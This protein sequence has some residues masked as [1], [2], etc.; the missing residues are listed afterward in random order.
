MAGTQIKGL[1]PVT[2]DDKTKLEQKLNPIQ[3]YV[4]F[5]FSITY[6]F[7]LT[8][9]TI[10]FIEAMRT[11]NPT[12]RHVLNIETAISL[13]AGYFYSAFLEKISVYEKDDRKI[14]WKDITMTRY[15]DWSMTTPLMLLVLCMVLSQNIGRII[16]LPVI[17]SVIALNYVMLYVGYLGENNVVTRGFANVSGFAAFFAMFALIFKEFV[18]P[19]YNFSNYV[20]FGIFVAI[21]ALYGVFYMWNEDYKNIG[22]NVLD[23]LAKCCFGLGLWAYYSKIVAL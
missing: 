19:K 16:H 18:S 1:N 5:S 9:A 23:C 4:K 2:G 3:Y 7:L 6:I 8:T 14:D 17:L 21:W 15:I 13:I 11:N 22:M 12:V 20:I 10:T